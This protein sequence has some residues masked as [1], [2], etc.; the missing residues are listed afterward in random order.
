[1][2]G[3]EYF[4]IAD[5]D[6]NDGTRALLESLEK[7]GIIKLLYQPSLGKRSQ[8]V[9]YERIIQRSIHEVDAILFID[10]DEFIVHN[11]FR[12]KSEYHYLQKLLK[13]NNIGMI[14]INWK[15]FGSS[16][17]KTKTKDLVLEK[18]NYHKKDEKN[19]INSPLKSVSR[20]ISI[21]NI[22]PHSSTL[23]SDE[24]V[25]VDANGD[26]IKEFLSEV[27]QNPTLNNRQGNALAV[28]INSPIR[29]HH[30][31]IKSYEEFIEKQQ[32]GCAMRGKQ[33][34]RDDNYFTKHDHNEILC[35]IPASKLKILKKTIMKLKNQLE[36]HTILNQNIVGNINIVN[37]NKII[38]WACAKNI[39]SLK[40]N[41]FVNDKYDGYV[42]T[43]FLKP[44]LKN[45]CDKNG[46]I[47]FIYT[48]HHPLQKDDKV[49]IT[50]YGNRFELGLFTI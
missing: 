48:F 34:K 36:Y 41:I 5:N 1:M 46:K 25:K 12:Q 10:A 17:L 42:Y 27:S 4:Y 9:A 13:N 29:I 28:P 14:A 37:K 16:G 20:L 30:Y 24:F 18:F 44:K 19:S 40:I 2:A 45:L 21:S 47:G 8:I 38:G 49:K 15:T 39:A 6:S 7:L 31:V 26:L 22:G 23:V 3:F 50:I 43:G 32:R 35:N 33:F 11:S